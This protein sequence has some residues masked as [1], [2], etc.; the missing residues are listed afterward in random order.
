MEK[1][2]CEQKQKICSLCYRSDVCKTQFGVCN[3]AECPIGALTI[4]NFEK[5]VKLAKP[6]R[7]LNEIIE[8]FFQEKEGTLPDEYTSL[9]QQY[10]K[11]KESLGESCS[12]C[13]LNS[14]RRHYKQKLM[15]I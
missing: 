8:I 12:S 4:D 9:Q 14:I 5:D 7:D 1:L 2:T 3:G 15:G 13:Q 11:D 6:K 10:L